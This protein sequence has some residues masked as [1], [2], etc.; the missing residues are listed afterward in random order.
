MIKRYIND[1]LGTNL[2][3]HNDTRGNIV[4]LFY[5]E[6]IN[7]VAKVKSEPNVLRGNH[8][9]K[10]TIQHML[11][12]QGSLE[13][14]YKPVDSEDPPKMVLAEVG[15]IISTEPFEIHALKIGPTGNEFIV[16]STGTRGGKDYETDTFRVD[17]IIGEK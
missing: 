16:F 9:H 13:Y 5:N 15:D 17:N 10:K 12:I 11:M 8:Y 2:E 6:T 4:D 14:W 1:I 3:C 7:H